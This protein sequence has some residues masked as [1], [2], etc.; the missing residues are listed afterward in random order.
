MFI[1]GRKRKSGGKGVDEKRLGEIIKD[2]LASYIR[3]EELREY[4]ERIESDKRKKQLW[5][6]LPT[7]K[8]IKLLRYALEKKGVEHGEKKIV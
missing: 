4:M 6:S 3:R 2:E 8:K 1:F 7:R 5:D